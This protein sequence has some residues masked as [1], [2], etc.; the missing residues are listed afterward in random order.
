M[1]QI[2]KALLTLLLLPA[3]IAELLGG[4]APPF[5]F[6][7]P[8]AFIFWI[9]LY[10]CGTLLI[11]ELRVRWNMQW[12]ILFLAI[13]YGVI[14]EGLTTKA[15]FNINWMDVGVYANYGHFFGILIPWSIVLLTYHVAVSTLLPIL[16]VD[17]TWP[18]LKNQPL[19][20][21][22]GM[23]FSSLGLILTVLLGLRFMGTRVGQETIPYFP[24]PIIIIGS[25]LIVTLL[26]SLGYVFRNLKIVSKNEIFKPRTFTILSFLFIILFTI[27]PHNLAKNNINIILLVAY[28]LLIIFLALIFTYKQ[29]LNINV[30]KEHKV[31][32][33][34]GI[35]L[36]FSIIAFFLELLGY[37]AM[38]L[39]GII[40]III[41]VKWKKKIITKSFKTN[42]I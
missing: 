41:L 20:K 10:G 18:E 2:N 36:Y 8:M 30:T 35:I 19:L 34:F 17:L 14:E 22:S 11:R 42:K 40:S 9:L 26:I 25:I 15:M 32:I 6:F 5:E 38:S 23:I 27:I 24:N 13:A 29:I 37:L 31:G 21:K 12:S 33:V 1:K 3:L 28:Q 39:I 4:S 16:I 7:N